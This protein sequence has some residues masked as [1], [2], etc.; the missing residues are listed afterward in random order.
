MLLIWSTW[1]AMVKIYHVA[2]MSIYSVYI[3]KLIK[4]LYAQLY[5]FLERSLNVWYG[6]NR[7]CS[8]KMLVYVVL[9]HIWVRTHGVT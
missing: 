3:L 4:R 9:V 1:V 2:F 5:N 8:E 6:T 7:M